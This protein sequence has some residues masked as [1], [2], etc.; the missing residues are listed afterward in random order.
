MDHA[1]ELSALLAQLARAQAALQEL[2]AE[3]AQLRKWAP[4]G[5]LLLR[6]P[7]LA[8]EK[9]LALLTQRD[10]AV[11]LSTSRTV[12]G[13]IET[14]TSH[15]DGGGGGGEGG[16]RT[17]SDAAAALAQQRGRG[18][19]AERGAPPPQ[20]QRGGA[21]GLPRGGARATPPSTP[22]TARASGQPWALAAER[23]TGS[24]DAESGSTSSSS[25]PLA[26]P[27]PAKAP[28]SQGL[29]GRVKS[30]FATSSPSTGAGAAPSAAAPEGMDAPP[31][32]GGGGLDF[33]SMSAM[34]QV[35]ALRQ[36]LII[37]KKMIQSGADELEIRTTQLSLAEDAKKHQRAEIAALEKA[38]D[39]ARLEKEEART[40][41]C[42]QHETLAMLDERCGTLTSTIAS[43][44]K[45]KGELEARGE[46]LSAALKHSREQLGASTRDCAGL[47][48]RLRVVE[49]SYLNS[50][51]ALRKLQ[52]TVERAE[53]ERGLGAAVAGGAAQGG[54]YAGDI[55]VSYEATI[56]GLRAEAVERKAAHEAE[57]AKL[58]AATAAAVAAAEAA[59]LIKA[60]A[61]ATA[62]AA[63]ADAA[64]ED[65]APEQSAA[66]CEGGCARALALEAEAA[67]L[68]TALAACEGDKKQQV[69][70]LAA[71]VKRLRKDLEQAKGAGAGVGEK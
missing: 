8:F 51:T 22:S 36:S 48:E 9:V 47:R 6:T 2:Q 37:A 52:G 50:E 40:E 10:L 26:S 20:H 38:R 61:A 41:L 68:R 58:R 11:L 70:M 14:Y 45:D 12:R 31:S 49:A 21:S 17:S 69:K 15:L 44:E 24:E 46:E 32:G 64:A 63:A 53:R 59:A 23:R 34:E 25:H 13:R 16:S 33:R 7:T 55:G 62:A 67:E 57:V 71:E 56:R 5:P 39:D 60:G 29:F 66:G 18:A 4:G 30:A 1:K 27:E 19:G 35:T 42:Q 28:S 65:A 43:L 54:G 3:V